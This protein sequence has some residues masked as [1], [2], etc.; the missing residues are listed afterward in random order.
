MIMELRIHRA[1]DDS[2]QKVVKEPL[3]LMG[4][5]MPDNLP[6]PNGLE[7]KHV[8]ASSPPP[9]ISFNLASGHH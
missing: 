9:A 1:A 4:G 8:S 7:M 3:E 6:L 2:W 5:G